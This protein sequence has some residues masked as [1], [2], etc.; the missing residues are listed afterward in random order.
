MAG[1]QGCG[2]G[3]VKACAPGETLGGGGK[4]EMLPAEAWGRP[5]MQGRR[6]DATSRVRWVYGP[7]PSGTEISKPVS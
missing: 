6:K 2:E 4:S 1:V 3:L 7:C 5:E